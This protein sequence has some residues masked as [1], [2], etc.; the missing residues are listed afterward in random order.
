MIC[1]TVKINTLKNV[2][3]LHTGPASFLLASGKY[4]ILWLL[5]HIATLSPQNFHKL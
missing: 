1:P 2:D 5:M 3:V 4:E